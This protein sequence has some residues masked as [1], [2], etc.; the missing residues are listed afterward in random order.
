MYYFH[1]L[2]DRHVNIIWYDLFILKQICIINKVFSIVWKD[3]ARFGAVSSPYFLRFEELYFH[4]L[5]CSYAPEP[6][7]LSDWS[8]LYCNATLGAR[9]VSDSAGAVSI[10]PMA[11]PVGVPVI[12][13]F[14]GIQSETKLN[15]DIQLSIPT[16]DELAELHYFSDCILPFNLSGLFLAYPL[17]SMPRYSLYLRTFELI[18]STIVSVV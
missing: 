14:I 12:G 17:P 8:I 18:V 6:R 15:D 10:Q 5:R 1:T 4:T 11:E 7:L 16:F 2:P 13:E 3:I 9:P